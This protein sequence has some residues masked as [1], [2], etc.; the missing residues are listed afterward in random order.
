MECKE[1]L[2]GFHQPALS[3]LFSLP[4][5]S[6]FCNF[7]QLSGNYNKLEYF[8][9]LFFFS[10]FTS[11]SHYSPLYHSQN[12]SQTILTKTEDFI[13]EPSGVLQEFLGIISSTNNF[14]G[15]HGPAEHAITL[16][17]C[18]KGKK[19]GKISSLT[20]TKTAKMTQR[21]PSDHEDTGSSKIFPTKY[22]QIDPMPPCL[23]LTSVVLSITW[24][25]CSSTQVERGQLSKGQPQ[26]VPSISFSQC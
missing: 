26:N 16:W 24:L 18:E 12:K 5:S 8:S 21:G 14:R 1:R 6:L 25:Y 7:S 13:F 20:M 4:H 11:K 17:R 15:L 19:K 10:E 23:T 2:C 22:L 3:S 9:S